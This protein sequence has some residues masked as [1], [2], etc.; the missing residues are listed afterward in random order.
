MDIKQA[1]NLVNLVNE[2]NRYEEILNQMEN[3]YSDEWEFRNSHT[4]ATVDFISEEWEE[5]RTMI[6]QRLYS[7][8]NEIEKLNT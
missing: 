5:I 1:K 2:Y 6:A 7:V 4:G 3:G 8:K